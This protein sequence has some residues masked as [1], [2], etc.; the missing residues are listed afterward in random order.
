MQISY[1]REIPERTRGRRSEVTTFTLGFSG[2][3]LPLLY[4]GQ[5]MLSMAV[6]PAS[7][8]KNLRCLRKSSVNGAG[9]HL[10]SRR[11]Q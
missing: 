8:F 4:E 6:V 1:L 3:K 9:R 5:P 10:R 7:K 11:N 2:V